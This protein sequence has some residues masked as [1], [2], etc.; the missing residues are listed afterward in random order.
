LLQFAERRLSP[1]RAVAER[2]A[3]NQSRR[4]ASQHPRK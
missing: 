2:T 1:S 4:S 3:P